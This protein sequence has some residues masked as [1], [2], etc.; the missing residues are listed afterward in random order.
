MKNLKFWYFSLSKNYA[1]EIDLFR[2][3][4]PFGSVSIFIFNCDL[5]YKKNFD[6]CP[7]FEIILIIMQLKIIEFNIYNKNHLTNKQYEEEH[8]VG[9]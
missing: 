5:H 3:M 1:L 6:H 9:E 8:A 4:K 2:W 7:K